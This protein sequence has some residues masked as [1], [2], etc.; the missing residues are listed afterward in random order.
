MFVKFLFFVY[1]LFTEIPRTFTL[2]TD[3]FPVQ[4]VSTQTRHWHCWSRRWVNYYCCYYFIVELSVY[5]LSNFHAS[6][7]MEK[8][9]LITIRK[10]VEW[11]WVC[12]PYPHELLQL[13]FLITAPRPVIIITSWRKILYIYNFKHQVK[14][15]EL[16]KQHQAVSN[17]QFRI[18]F[19]VIF[20][21]Y[22][23]NVL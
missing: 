21:I 3:Q 18:Y 8:R 1:F 11:I 12:F 5:F 4:G 16:S 2:V 22:F 6:Y 20:T 10:T 14:K 15:H 17:K 9:N 23:F 13:N 7:R 19:L